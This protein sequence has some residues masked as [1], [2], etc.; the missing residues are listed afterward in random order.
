MVPWGDIDKHPAGGAL[1]RVVA[2][3][4][5][6]DY[7]GGSIELICAEIR[8]D[9]FR[10]HWRISGEAV[11]DYFGPRPILERMMDRAGPFS[12]V[13]NDGTRLNVHREQSAGSEHEGYGAVIVWPVPSA[14]AVAFS[15]RSNRP[16][17]DATVLI[18]LE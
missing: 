1:V 6:L 11:A 18:D 8:E 4:K 10:V 7:S 16:E 17:S 12:A 9:F 14:G 2:I 5:V 3:G 15:A 13:A